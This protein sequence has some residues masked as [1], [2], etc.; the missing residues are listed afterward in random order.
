MDG[1]I[2]R[3]IVVVIATIALG[4]RLRRRDVTPVPR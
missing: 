4:C 1:K 2:K 3:L